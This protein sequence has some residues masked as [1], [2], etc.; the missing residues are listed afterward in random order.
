MINLFNEFNLARFDER[1]ATK[2]VDGV[3]HFKVRAFDTNGVWIDR[4]WVVNRPG[5]TNLNARYLNYTALQLGGETERYEFRSNA[6]PAAVELEM[7]LL[8]DKVWQRF[9]GLPTPTAQ[10]NYLT[11]QAGRVHLFR[12]R[13]SIRNVDPVAYQ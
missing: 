7:G 3:V 4:A 10:S 2:V 11:N 13:V 5:V 1:R 12:S 8:E 9:Q 6:V